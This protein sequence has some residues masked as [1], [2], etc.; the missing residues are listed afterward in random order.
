MRPRRASLI[1]VSQFAAAAGKRSQSQSLQ[2]MLSQCLSNMAEDAAAEYDQSLS[3]LTKRLLANDPS[4]SR[5]SLDEQVEPPPEACQR[6][7]VGSLIS[8]LADSTHV[9]DVFIT[10]T[11][12]GTWEAWQWHMLLVV[13]AQV[14]QL[15]W[16]D[17]LTSGRAVPLELLAHLLLH[18]QL[19]E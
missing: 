3:W 14:R 4:L 11:F 10:K 5:L 2:L 9:T 16:L 18:A 8:A 15:A 1:F 17:L 6:E 7:H 12:V 13:L 19:L